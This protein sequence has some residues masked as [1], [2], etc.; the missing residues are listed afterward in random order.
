MKLKELL[1]YSQRIKEESSRNGKVEII[2]EY[3]KK[4]K[5][6]EAYFGVHYIAGRLPQGRMNLA[7]K[8]LSELL[9]VSL[10]VGKTPLLEEID[11][12]MDEVQRNRGKTK[13]EVL[14][15]L[16]SRLTKEEREYLLSLIFGEAQQ[17]AGE[18][19]VKLAI[20]QHFG[21]SENDIEDAY[22]HNPDLGKLFQHLLIK[23]KKAIKEVGIRLFRPVKP[24]LAQ[25]SESIE[26]V[27]N[28][29]DEAAIEYKLDGVRIQVHKDREKVR[30]FSR[31]LK[32]RTL[33]FP[34][35]VSI[36]KKLP[37]DCFIID[38]EA[39][40]L[41]R[42][43]RIVP[44]QILARRTT[45][46]K[47]IEKV[48]K[49]IPVQPQFFD[50]LYLENE[51]LT[52]LTYRER[53]RVLTDIVRD[54]NHRAART[55]PKNVNKA[56]GFF[57]QAI[58]AGNEGVVIKGLESPYRPGKRGKHWFKIKHTHTVDCVILAAEWGYGRRKGWLSNIHLGV[59]DETKTKYLMVGKTFKGLTDKMLQWMTDTLPQYK[60]HEDRSTVYVRPAIVVEITFNEVQAS[61]RYDSGFS[62]RFARVKQFRK[63]KSPQDINTIIDLEEIKSMTSLPATEEE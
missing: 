47:D 30:I 10:I 26:D 24:M 20:A 11:R 7:W 14:K 54:E 43:G 61:P 22:L 16:F 35:L 25:V 57:E 23:G 32:D 49:D 48:M 13:Y 52:P 38:G 6:N 33:H 31:N 34:E 46:K 21:L 17:G 51:D 53:F 41:D 42:K 9:K 50:I 44:F 29:L 62:L 15:P 55:L 63:D 1:K 12:T 39:I 4:L 2:K 36:V 8:G 37:A 27:L 56:Q 59:L 60:V 45:R 58:Q 3:L 28:E 19:V 18:G 5:Q 40:A